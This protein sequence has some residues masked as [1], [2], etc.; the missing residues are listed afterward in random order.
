MHFVADQL[1]CRFQTQEVQLQYRYQCGPVY[2]DTL[3][4]EK[5]SLRGYN[6]GQVIV[7]ENFHTKFYL[8]K[9]KADAFVSFNRG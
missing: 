8:M 9:S 2:S 6:S 5:N 1:T 7:A 3:F 4:H